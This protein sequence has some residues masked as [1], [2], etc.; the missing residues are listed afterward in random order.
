M[1]GK[2]KKDRIMFKNNLYF[3]KGFRTH[4]ANII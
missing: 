1:I 4:V 3:M 2:S